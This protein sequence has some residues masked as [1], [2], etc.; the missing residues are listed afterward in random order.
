MKI[1]IAIAAFLIGMLLVFK[2][3]KCTNKKDKQV[4]QIAV[5]QQDPGKR[6]LDINDI[7]H[8]EKRI[9]Q[10]EIKAMQVFHKREIDSILRLYNLAKKQLVGY[11]NTAVRVSGQITAPVKVIRVFDTVS[12]M[13]TSTGKSPFCF[14]G[15]Q[16]S[17]T[18]SFLQV[19]GWVDSVQATLV[20][21]MNLELKQRNYWR[22][23]HKFWFIRFG[24]KIYYSDVYS[25]N[26][27]V[28]I[29]NLETIQIQ[30]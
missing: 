15:Y 14:S 5:T 3:T 26:P 16:F 21:D 20:Y 7:H 2:A 25:T 22:R 10:A 1:Y 12:A 18:D 13:D 17:W 11:S 24:K 9:E 30:Q 27:N 4:A 28:H 19:S 23:K 6:W 8:L 29:V